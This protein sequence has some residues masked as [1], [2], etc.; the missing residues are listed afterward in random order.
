[1]KTDKD[2]LFEAVRLLKKVDSKGYRQE[3][4]LIDTSWAMPIEVLW[5][6]EGFLEKYKSRDDNPDE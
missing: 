4:L 5:Q 1:M 2:F 6:I 3:G